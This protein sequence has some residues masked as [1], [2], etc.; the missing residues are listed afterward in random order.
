MTQYDVISPEVAQNYG[1]LYKQLKNDHLAEKLC[2]GKYFGTRRT[3]KMLI[4][5]KIQNPSIF[6]HIMTS[7]NPKNWKIGQ[8][9]RQKLDFFK[10]SRI[11][12]RLK[13]YTQRITYL[14]KKIRKKFFFTQ[15][16]VQIPQKRAK[17]GQ[18]GSKIRQKSDFLKYIHHIYRWKRYG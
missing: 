2:T 9:I 18:Y 15:N 12:Y 5:H 13:A 14:T 7:S 3:M 4:F 1:H 10:Y 17:K 8:K 6:W 11:I 16:S